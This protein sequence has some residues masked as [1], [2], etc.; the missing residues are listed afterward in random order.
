[1]SNKSQYSILRKTLAKLGIEGNFH[2]DKT[3]TKE[4]QQKLLLKV[5]QKLFL[6]VLFLGLRDGSPLSTL[7]NI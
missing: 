4:L 7:Y 1:M 6:K 3:I 2:C 5:Q